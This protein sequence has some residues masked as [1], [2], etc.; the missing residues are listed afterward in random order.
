MIPC[1]KIVLYSG[2]SIKCT[3]LRLSYKRQSPSDLSHSIEGQTYFSKA[4][5]QEVTTA[6]E[7]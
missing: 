7:V 4:Y 1:S 5:L 6:V 3:P 2:T